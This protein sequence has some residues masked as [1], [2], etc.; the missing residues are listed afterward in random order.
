M[1]RVMKQTAAVFILFRWVM[2]EPRKHYILRS[3]LGSYFL[4]HT[5]TAH[6]YSCQI[7]L[8]PSSFSITRVPSSA[9]F[10][11]KENIMAKNK[12]KKII[13]IDMIP[14]YSQQ[15]RSSPPKRRTDFSV[16]TSTP[17]PPHS[18]IF[19][20]PP[21]SSS[22]EIRLSNFIANHLKETKMRVKQFPED[23]PARCSNSQD[24]RSVCSSEFSDD[25]VTDVDSDQGLNLASNRDASIKKI[26]IFK[27]SEST[28]HGS[29]VSD[30]NSLAATPGNV[31]WARTACQM[32]W[33]AEIMVE[34]S[35][36]SDPT[37]D[38]HVRVQFYGNHSSAWIDPMTD[39]SAF[40]DSF[41]ERST[42]P[43]EDFQE[44]LKQAIQRKEQLSSC[45]TLSSDRS[46]HSDQQDRSS[47]KWTSC[48]S[49]TIM[50][51][52]QERRRGKRE[53]KR[54]V[55]FDELSF[56]LKSERK[57]RRLKIMRYLGLVAPIGSPF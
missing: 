45:R 48:T 43:S 30:S 50:D 51:D 29:P 10:Q 16:F 35:T 7:Q 36:S 18:S 3:T 24:H 4:Q 33:P 42:N 28:P 32:W 44:A 6:F 12:K 11:S 56:P 41:E 38:R 52:L 55:H 26:G 23:T 19:F 8:P 31:V 13:S 39:I 21:G 53:R 14:K 1:C 49:S 54:K 9:S 47:D 46:A 20:N 37:C 2:V 17:P 40:E 5:S 25:P 22:G 15:P 27:M 57:V 34:K